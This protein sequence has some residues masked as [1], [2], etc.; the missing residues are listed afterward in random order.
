MA[1]LAAKSDAAT[2]FMAERL[3][4]TGLLYAKTDKA[5]SFDN[6]RV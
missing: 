3:G 5:T 2:S 4:T 6:Q 1:S